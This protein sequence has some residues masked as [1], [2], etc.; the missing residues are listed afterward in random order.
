M[1]T[2]AINSDNAF[3]AGS[4]QDAVFLA[5]LGTTLPEDLS[6][7]PAAFEHV[8][9]IHLDGLTEAPL[10]SKTEIRGH[11]GQAVVRSRME[12]PGT[13][14]SFTGLESK[15]LTDKLRY[16]EKSTSVSG[17]IRKTVRGP[18]QKV[19]SMVAVVDVYDMGFTTRQKRHV[20]EQWDITPNGERIYAGSDI[21]SYPFLA[22]VIGDYYVLENESGTLPPAQQ[23]PVLTSV[24]PTTAAAGASVVLT[25]TGFTAATGVRFGTA[26]AVF[27]ID[28]DTKITATVPAGT[29]GS[30]PIRVYK[31]VLDSDA[32]PFTRS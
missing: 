11:Q 29:A 7:L 28:S 17:G 31:G 10:G 4:D 9:W 6:D 12:T 18:G 21:A 15:P 14:W 13:Q 1:A 27:T 20:F 26:N 8:G 3:I 30:A 24:S 16:V 22:D 5:P 32:V 25:G 19:T 2:G 23:E